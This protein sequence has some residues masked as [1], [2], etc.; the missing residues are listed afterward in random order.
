MNTIVFSSM[1]EDAGKTSVIVGVA[2]ALGK[3][4]G[5]MKP[6]GDRLLYRKKRLWDYDAAVITSLFNLDEN[7]EDMSVGFEHAKLRYMYDEEGTKKKLQDGLSNTGKGKDVLF[8]EGG[9]DL[10]H[11]TSIHLDSISLAKHMNG[12]LFV[13]VSGSDDAIV[14]DIHFIKKYVDTKGVN[15]GG[16]IINK[17]KDLDDFKNTYMKEIEKTGIKVAGIIPYKSELSYLSV[18]YLADYMF[19]KVIAGEGGLNNIVKS[20]FVGAMSAS[21][22]L[23]NLLF[24]NENKLFITSGDRSD[25]ILAALETSTAAIVLTNNILPTPAII[26]RATEKNVPLLLVSSDTYQAAR[27]ID[28]ADSLI[29]KDDKGKVEMLKLLAT[30]YIDLKAFA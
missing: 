17:V 3:K 25:I 5:Y 16:V 23:R 13:V 24:K 29:T 10:E 9:C 19:A 6:L 14:D 28:N 1:R 26:S 18:S 22:A 7:P 8:V 4:I 21:E 11:G 27:Q 20:V 2:S 12:K 15:F 30:D